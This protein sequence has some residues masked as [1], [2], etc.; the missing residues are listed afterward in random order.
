MNSFLL[1][2]EEK[3]GTGQL[4]LLKEIYDSFY[5]CEFS[6]YFDYETS[7][8][9]RDL[10]KGHQ[11]DNSYWCSKK[12][13]L[14]RDSAIIRP[15]IPYSLISSFCSEKKFLGKGIIRV[16]CGEFP[17]GTGFYS[18]S[19]KLE[20]LYNKGK[21]KKVEKTY[22]LFTKNGDN[23]DLVSY[24]VYEYK[25]EKYIRY[26]L[27]QDL[28][29]KGNYFLIEKG[30]VKWFSVDPIY[31]FADINNDIAITSDIVFPKIPTK[32][33][34]GKLFINKIMNIWLKEMLTD[35]ERL[36]R[37]E[38]V[39]NIYNFDFR[40]L[41]EE[42]IIRGAI[43]SNIP[44]Y[45]HGKSS[46]G[47]S[48]RVKQL[49]PDCEI[50]YLDN[51][52]K[53][54]LI[55]KSIYNSET[56]K[57]EDV[58]PTWYLNIKEKCERE[59]NKIHIIFFDELTHAPYEFQNMLFNIVLDHNINGKWNL[60]LNARIVA[61]GNEKSESISAN[62]M[63]EQLFNRFAHVYIN[64]TVEKWLEWAI[65]PEESYERLDYVDDKQTSKIHPAIYS[66]VAYKDA[67]GENVLNTSY[68]GDY[69]NAD[70]RKWEMASKVLYNT[71]EP[72]MFRALIGNKLT[73]D[74]IEFVKQKGISIEDVV[75]HNYSSK[76]LDMNLSECYA[77]AAS[78]SFVDDE[79]FEVARDFMRQFG[80][81]PTTTF[82]NMWAS[83][84]KQRL[85]RLKRNI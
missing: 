4:P 59:P 54:S 68:T 50:V 78:L 16:A 34:D 32:D 35:R 81:E 21:L 33:T 25:N 57:M 60:P 42:E 7:K 12:S 79:H 10:E 18:E 52:S 58:P 9:P 66:F 85:K 39:N 41:S 82:E 76:N 61:A 69:A 19:S 62:E 55:G 31:W 43:I 71:K 51:A 45:L 20:N 72:E 13:Y 14:S 56:K 5:R 15:V 6:R 28:R 46:V 37:E 40:S 1:N 80:D 63:V 26:V 77:T 24:P 67:M 70:P 8:Y 30:T 84:N 48:S 23:I 17:Q 53:E 75:N 38:A 47:K 49:D 3:R 36:L 22:T 44:V 65:T 29:K 11:E 64:T 73:N 83:G 2:D 27:K 74:F